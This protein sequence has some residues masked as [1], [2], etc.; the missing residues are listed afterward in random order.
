MAKDK[1]AA[2]SACI[3]SSTANGAICQNL[4]FLSKPNGGAAYGVFD[5]YAS[6]RRRLAD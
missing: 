4:R 3:I 1:I 5:W 6:E 2:W